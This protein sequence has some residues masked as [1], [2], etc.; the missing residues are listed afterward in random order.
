MP[1]D[2]NFSGKVNFDKGCDLRINNTAMTS[3]AADLNLAGNSLKA[4]VNTSATVTNLMPVTLVAGQVNILN[5]SGE[6]LT[7]TNTI[8]LAAAASTD[9]GKFTVIMNGPTSTNVLK[10]AAIT[11]F[12]KG[13]EINLASNECAIVFATATNKYYSIGNQ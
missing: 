13:P 7:A 8:T 11:G 6:L 2:V 1:Q 9:V 10:I 3:S 12:Y 5:A 4:T